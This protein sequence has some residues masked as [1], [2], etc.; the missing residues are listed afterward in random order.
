MLGLWLMKKWAVY[1]YAAITI[2]N[3][4]ALLL[5]GRWNLASLLIPAIVLYVGYKNLSKMS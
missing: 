5:M 1:A 2:I 3:Q 4:I